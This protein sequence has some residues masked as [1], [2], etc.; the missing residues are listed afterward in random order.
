MLTAEGALLWR[1]GSREGLFLSSIFLSVLLS[2]RDVQVKQESTDVPL[3]PL[4][5]RKRLPDR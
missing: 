3:L 1:A 5:K 2:S 4:G